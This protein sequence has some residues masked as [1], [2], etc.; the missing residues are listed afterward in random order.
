[1]HV[2]GGRSGEGPSVL[3]VEVDGE[4]QGWERGKRGWCRQERGWRG[5]R[6]GSDS[7]WVWRPGAGTQGLTPEP[8]VGIS[9]QWS[10]KASVGSPT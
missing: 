6:R 5:P 1:M 3:A 10:I 4:G 2:A 7:H 9:G 8:V